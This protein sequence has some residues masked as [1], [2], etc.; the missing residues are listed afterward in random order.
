M[1]LV[2]LATPQHRTAPAL[3]PIAC[4]LAAF[5][6]GMSAGRLG[7][8]AQAQPA[9]PTN[10]L[11]IQWVVLEVLSNNPSLKAARANW[12]ALKARIPQARA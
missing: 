5:L 11:S 1:K 6:A 10:E 2:L 3:F 4:V 7:A 12:E 8:E 9:Q